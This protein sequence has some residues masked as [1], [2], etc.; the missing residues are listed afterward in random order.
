MVGSAIEKKLHAAWQLSIQKPMLLAT[1]CIY[2]K[3]LK[4]PMRKSAYQ[5]FLGLS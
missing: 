3:T 4:E 5:D 2:P 1:S